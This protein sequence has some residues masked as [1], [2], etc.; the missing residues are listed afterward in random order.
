[1]VSSPKLHKHFF[2]PNTNVLCSHAGLIF[3]GFEKSIFLPPL[4][5]N[6]VNCNILQCSLDLKITFR[7]TESNITIPL[8]RILSSYGLVTL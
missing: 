2:S 1:M 4:Q 6:G 5:Y 8:S 3:P 7:P